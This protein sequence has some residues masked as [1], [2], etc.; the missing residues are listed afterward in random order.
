MFHMGDGNLS[1]KME[2]KAPWVTAHLE[3]G[4]PAGHAQA[5]KKT[6]ILLV[7]FLYVILQLLLFIFKLIHHRNTPTQANF[8]KN[9][10]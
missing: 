4:T 6:P 7:S 2:N 9:S 5:K 1:P 3:K 10:T 8:S